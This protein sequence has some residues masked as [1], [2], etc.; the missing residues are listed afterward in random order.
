M[1]SAPEAKLR[2]YASLFR[3]STDVYALR[4]ENRRDGRSGWMPAI[5]GY[6]RKG[7][8]PSRRTL[9][10]TTAEVI[11]KHLRGDLHIGFYPAVDR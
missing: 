11:A 10:D 6:W 3:C 9:S 1:R 8:E 5:N 4:W 7:M 2:F